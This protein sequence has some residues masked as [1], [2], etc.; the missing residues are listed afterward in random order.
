MKIVDLMQR[1]P[2]TVEPETPVGDIARAM[3]RARTREVVVVEA[4]RV[5]GVITATD[6]LAKHATLHFP[7]YFSLLGYSIPFEPARDKREIEK[8]LATTA[9]QLMS[10]EPVTIS[11]DSDVDE[12]ATIMLDRNVSCLPVVREGHLEGMIDESDIVRVLVVEE[13]G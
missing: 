5:A 6:L 2:V 7:T 3:T 12:A 11:P 8:A 1:E 4:G 9:K 13:S 10:T